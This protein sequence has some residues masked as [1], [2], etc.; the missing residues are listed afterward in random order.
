MALI[1]PAPAQIKN[2][3][4]PTSGSDAATKQYVDSI[5]GNSAD[6]AAAGD[7][8]QVQFNN[9]GVLGGN[10]NFTFDSTTSLLTIT[11]NILATNAN[12]G[13]LVT[14]NYFAG[15]LT[16][17]SQPN[18]T[19]VGTLGNL[20]VTGDVSGNNFTVNGNLT[21]IGSTITVNNEVVN[22]T[23]TVTGN[24]SAG[25]VSF[26]GSNVSLGNISNLHISGG[27][28][29]QYLTTDGHGLLSFTS[30]SSLLATVDTFIGDNTKTIFT[31]SSAPSSTNYTFVTIHGLAQPRS[32]YT[33][34]GTTLTFTTAPPTDA[35]IEITTLGGNVVN[36]ALS[37]VSVPVTSTSPGSVGQLAYDE[38]YMYVCINTNQWIKSALV[39]GW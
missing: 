11:G 32:Y 6:I 23:E 25:N 8:T 12:L 33:I 22:Q 38:S 14:S 36:S 31:L 10:S 2:L 34:A 29:G 27:S 5:I 21:V 9:N 37:I 28:N 16:T 35:I 20:S 24:L 7:N 30:P 15:V 26:T 13:N 39:T 17:S 19:S 1:F 4:D 3:L 18:I